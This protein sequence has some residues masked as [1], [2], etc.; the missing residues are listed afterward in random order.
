MPG[1]KKIVDFDEFFK[2]LDV[3]KHT[4]FPQFYCATIINVHRFENFPQFSVM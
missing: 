4:Y 2:I 1:N 3:I